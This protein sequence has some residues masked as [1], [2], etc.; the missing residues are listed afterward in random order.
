LPNPMASRW[1]RGLLNF[2]A[3]MRVPD[4]FHVASRDD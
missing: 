1:T 2:P 4:R 3:S